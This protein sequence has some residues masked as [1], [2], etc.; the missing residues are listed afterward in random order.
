MVGWARMIAA[1]AA[2][3][4]CSIAYGCQNTTA[5]L[6]G[7]AKPEGKVVRVGLMDASASSATLVFDV[8]IRNPYDS[9]LAVVSFD[10]DLSSGGQRFTSGMVET[11]GVIDAGN[12]RVA[13]VSVEVKYSELQAAVLDTMPGTAV[14][15]IAELGVTVDAPLMGEMRIPLTQGG[16]LPIPLPIELK[17]LK[18]AWKTLAENEASGT[19]TAGLSNPNRFQIDVVSIAYW[20]YVGETKVSSSAVVSETALRPGGQANVTIP[21]SIVP[22]ELGEEAPAIVGGQQIEYRLAGDVQVRTVYGTM[23]LPIVTK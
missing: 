20:L 6:G 13:P 9:P 16:E 4:A 21:V 10:Y 18:V 14:P 23:T 3:A 8:E 11:E 2:I 12:T 17:S 1:A 15:Y 7:V 5:L 22:N 19:L